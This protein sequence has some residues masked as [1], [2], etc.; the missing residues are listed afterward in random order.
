MKTFAVPNTKCVS[1]TTRGYNGDSVSKLEVW[2]RRSRKVY[3][4]REMYVEDRAL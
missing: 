4:R 3:E 2:V 1:K